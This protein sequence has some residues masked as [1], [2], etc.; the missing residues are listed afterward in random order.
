[1]SSAE[2]APSL[3][4]RRS[5]RETADRILDAAEALFAERGF[6]GTTLRDVASRVGVRN[7]SLYNHFASKEALYA[8]VLERVTRPVLEG[9]TELLA[10]G[11]QGADGTRRFVERIWGLLARHPNLPRLIQHETLTGGERFSPT[12]RDSIR[13]IFERAR[14]VA[15]ASPARH[16]W[17]EDQLPL[18]VLALY[19]T[20]VGYFTIAPLY[21]ELNG[22]DLLSSEALVRQTRFFSELVERLLDGGRGPGPRKGPAW[23]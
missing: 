23:T 2:P 5:G 8:A 12:L 17:K 13:P 19:H 21:R 11:E 10:E 15:L 22:V 20:L 6:A 1:M 9:L 3:E 16:H 4:T 14:E 18:L 7:P